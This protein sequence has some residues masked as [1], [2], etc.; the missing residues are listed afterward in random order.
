LDQQLRIVIERLA[1]RRPI[2]QCISRPSLNFDCAESGQQASWACFSR[3]TTLRVEVGLHGNAGRML[4]PYSCETANIVCISI[5]ARHQR[6]ELG[7]G[8]WAGVPCRRCE[9]GRDS[10]PDRRDCYSGWSRLT[11]VS[12][13]CCLPTRRLPATYRR[14][15]ISP[16][17]W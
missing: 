17:E 16:L 1:A 13:Q 8:G 4:V 5:G 10:P 6:P 11:S 12:L 2:L 3:P 7:T 14:L 15:N 9:S